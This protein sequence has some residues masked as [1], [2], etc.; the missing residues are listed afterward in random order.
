MQRSPVRGFVSALPLLIAV[1]LVPGSVW[2]QGVPP[3]SAGATLFE[4]KC[5]ACH[6]LEANR[7]GPMLR[8]VVGRKVASAAGYEYS[9][10]LRRVKGQWDAARLEKWLQD[11]QSVAAGTRM[12]FSL[13][14]AAERKAVIQYLA[15]TGA[16]GR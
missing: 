4:S 1:G 8:G 14:S 6:S 12:A 13:P 16:T 7:I 5:L 10:A 3:S 2:A 11:P 15:S 9:D